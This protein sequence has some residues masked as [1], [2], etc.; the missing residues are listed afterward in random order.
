M[1]FVTVGTQKF[2]F[3]RLLAWIDELVAEGKIKD[4]VFAQIGNSTYQPKGYKFT[5]FVSP[6][7]FADLVGECT[8]YITHGGVGSLVQGLNAGK[9]VIAVARLAKFD[10]HI[11]D[12]QLQITGKYASLG[13]IMLADSKE[14]LLEC[15]NNA[16]KFNSSYKKTA[17][18]AIAICD[19]IDNFIKTGGKTK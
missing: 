7:Q 13:Y 3:N 16:D 1:I 14:G 2:Q 11:D 17:N 15:I 18:S 9:K 6:H 12:H 5:Q 4:E 10:E 8:T 19:Y